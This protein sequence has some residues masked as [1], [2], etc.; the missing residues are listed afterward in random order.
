MINYFLLET[1]NDIINRQL[2]NFCILVPDNKIKN[3]L[4][5]NY[6]IYT[7]DE[8]VTYKR[9][10]LSHFD[11]ILK[12]FRIYK[13][14]I[15]DIDFNNFWNI[16]NILLQDFDTIDRCCINSDDLFN[17]V[18][19]YKKYS[20]SFEEL[21]EN[22][23]EIILSFWNVFNSN[24]YKKEISLRFF[25]NIRKL[26]NSFKSSLN[27]EW[28]MGLCY[29]NFDI[30]LIQSYDNIV[31]IGITP[32]YQSDKQL[33][34]YIKMYKN[35]FFYLDLDSYY[36]NNPKHEI[37]KILLDYESLNI[38]SSITNNINNVSIKVLQCNSDFEQINSCVNI[39]H[40]ISENYD[41]AIVITDINILSQLVLIIDFPIKSSLDYPVKNTHFYN[42]L[43]SE[44]KKDI[45]IT[46]IIN[47]VRNY[48]SQDNYDSLVI[49]EF[50]KYLTS[51]SDID[52]DI[53]DTKNFVKKIFQT[54]HIPFESDSNSNIH[55]MLL[56]ET[57]NLSFDY[58]FIIGANDDNLPV[59]YSYRSFIPYN[60]RKGFN[61]PT[62]E[63]HIYSY[64]FYR[65]L[66][67]TKNLFIIYNQQKDEITR[68]IT[69]LKYESNIKIET[70]SNK[71]SINSCFKNFDVI[72]DK[73]E[74]IS[75][76][77]FFYDKITPTFINTYLDCQIKFFYKYI[78]QIKSSTS[79]EASFG[80]NIHYVLKNIYSNKPMINKKTMELIK[81]NAIKLIN[82]VF[83]INNDFNKI[84][85]KN[86]ATKMII[87]FLEYEEKYNDSCQIISIE[88]PIHSYKIDKYSINGIIDRVDNMNSKTR[89]I[90]YKT[91]QTNNNIK[92][93]S[94]LFDKEKTRINSSKILQILMYSMT[95]KDSIP[96]IISLRDI[97]KEHVV[98]VNNQPINMTS[99]IISELKDYLLIILNEIFDSNISF[100]STNNQKI[101]AFCPYVVFCKNTNL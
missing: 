41:I 39:I 32:L 33:I 37:N 34:N 92:S 49:N 85:E 6:H 51:L 21:P 66:H 44:I 20:L 55:I 95:I 96:M 22:Q 35:T 42:F 10:I 43:I 94:E 54:I 46:Q 93:I 53:T 14:N 30:Q 40:S 19:E 80:T 70:I 57:I 48:I 88:H 36:C 2:S 67:N 83:I 69:Q 77:N 31:F 18:I 60:L 97:N 27:N 81:Q 78:K 65:L 63:S 52:K 90:D 11:I 45:N 98:K 73:K 87:N 7:L 13:T 61:L 99:N 71:Y 101:C 4:I 28:Y 16:G 64:Y 62:N 72:I 50:L 58:V 76:L 3:I 25:D 59:K 75:K 47:I 23:K 100:K 38:C 8:V 26:Y 84:L 79:Q 17:N 68:Y 9:N 89:V 29:R 56:A 82:E 15:K 1:I 74:Y 12:L 24:K 91:C 5:D 86:I